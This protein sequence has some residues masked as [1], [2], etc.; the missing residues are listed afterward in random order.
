MK[1]TARVESLVPVVGGLPLLRQ[2][3]VVDALGVEPLELLVVV[4]PHVVPHVLG[5]GPVDISSLGSKPSNIGTHEDNSSTHDDEEWL[6]GGVVLQGLEG[7]PLEAGDL[8]VSLSATQ[9][10]EHGMVSST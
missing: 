8:V 3:G 5:L 4:V 10:V 7:H 9:S 1:T 2:S 6:Q